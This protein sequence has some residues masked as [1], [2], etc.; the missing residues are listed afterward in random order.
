MELSSIG[1]Q[2]FAVESITKKRV[3]KGNVE[4]LLKWQGWPPKYST[5]EPEDNILDPRLVLAYEENQQKIRALAYRKKGLR[6]RSLVLRNIFAMD[7]RSAHKAPDKPPSRLR[8]SLTRAMSTDVDQSERGGAYC[9]PARRRNKQL[10]SKRRS[11]VRSNRA[12]EEKKVDEWEDTS[13][14]E[15]HESESTAEERQADSLYGHSECS[16]P[17]VLE[18]QDLEMDVEENSDKTWS[19]PQKQGAATV[20]CEQS[21]DNAS[22]LDNGEADVVTEGNR[23][24]S[25]MCEEEAQSGPECPGA[26]LT[27]NTTSATA[28][29]GDAAA[30]NQNIIATTP[31]EHPRK[32]IMTE[33]TINSLT[34]TFKEAAVAEGFF[35]DC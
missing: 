10:A 20:A 32:V 30:H 14:E 16:S 12:V 7:L 21:K 15:K 8:L 35:K 19:D 26:H 18:R 3:R 33:V 24:E 6:P 28:G 27:D 25:D 2:V 29:G 1:D 22:P 31:S 4:Y 11:S 34:V 23:S 9:R 13:E 5:W 17:P